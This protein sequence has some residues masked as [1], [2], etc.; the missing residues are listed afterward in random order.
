MVGAHSTGNR[1]PDLSSANTAWDSQADRRNATMKRMSPIGRSF[2]FADLA[3]CRAL[4]TGASSG[5]GR[6][7][8]LELARAGADVIVHHR[9]S[10]HA[11]EQVAADIRA[12]Q[13]T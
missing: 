9:R 3:G 5:I 7:I 6:A 13:R 2:D 12:L 11:A 4:V 8:A 10:E 1:P